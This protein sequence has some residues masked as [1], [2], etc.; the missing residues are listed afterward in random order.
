MGRNKALN[1]YHF[2]A[3][4]V[5]WPLEPSQCN[6]RNM[7][8]MRWL[9][10]DEL[11]EMVTVL[12]K[13][14]PQGAVTAK[15]ALKMMTAACG[16]TD[17]GGYPSALWKLQANIVENRLKNLENYGGESAEF[18]LALVVIH[19]A[20]RVWIAQL[21]REELDEIGAEEF[22]RDARA[23]FDRLRAIMDVASFAS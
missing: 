14:V 15:Q 16:V 11:Q 5:L 2:K 3:F 12:R 17:S 23:A 22:L 6:L 7:E 10:K 13:H 18:E 20:M 8:P 9:K 1:G 21:T 19:G 4:V